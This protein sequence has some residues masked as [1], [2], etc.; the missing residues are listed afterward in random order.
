MSFTES[1]APNTL[2]KLVTND[3]SAKFENI[4][5]QLKTY[6][7][8]DDKEEDTEGEVKVEE[9]EDINVYKNALEAL[10]GN[11]SA[12]PLFPKL[13]SLMG[14]KENDVV[15]AKNFLENMQER[16]LSRK[17]ALTLYSAMKSYSILNSFQQKNN[18][19][20]SAKI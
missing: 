18:S 13:N 2:N 5:S 12:N 11:K 14:K 10:Y 7:N 9:Y 8:Q 20:I 17:S 16:G 15:S 1:I 4:T 6:L 19:F 3:M